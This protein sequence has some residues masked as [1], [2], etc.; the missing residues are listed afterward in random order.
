MKQLLQKYLP[1]GTLR[2]R[3]QDSHIRSPPKNIE[4]RCLLI[5][6]S[7]PYVSTK[8]VHTV[9]TMRWS[10]CCFHHNSLEVTQTGFWRICF[11]F[12]HQN[13][14]CWLIF[15]WLNRWLHCVI[16]IGLSGKIF[17]KWFL[18]F[19][20]LC[21]DW[22]KGSLD[23]FSWFFATLVNAQQ[24]GCS[25]GMGCL[26]INELANCFVELPPLSLHISKDMSFVPFSSSPADFSSFM[27]FE[28]SVSRSVTWRNVMFSADELI[29]SPNSY[30][31]SPCCFIPS[32]S[33]SSV[34]KIV[35]QC[36]FNCFP[37]VEGHLFF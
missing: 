7:C 33:C 32:C 4:T 11:H 23:I 27:E 14:F 18:K 36:P 37:E 1:F 29:N 3:I 22:T 16:I 15:C 28:H 24:F 20:Q 31:N 12:Q 8:M 26:W 25:H 21:K 17:C 19:F 30:L 10:N 6:S 34:P 35:F 9:H 13:K 2:S 5:V